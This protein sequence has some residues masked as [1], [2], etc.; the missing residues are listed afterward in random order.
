MRRAETCVVLCAGRGERM[1]PPLAKTVIDVGGKPIF[2]YVVEFWK[3]SVDRFV[4]VVGYKKRDVINEAREL[5]VAGRCT[6]VNQSDP[7]GIAH[8]VSLVRRYVGKDFIVA[9]GDCLQTGAFANWPGRMDCG[10]GVWRGGCD[11][12]IRQGYSV[13]TEDERV[14]RVVEKP[15]G[16]DI[17]GNCGMGTYYFNRKVFEHIARTPPS[18]LRNE[19]EITDVVQGMINNGYDVKPLWFNGGYI[20]VTYVSDLDRAARMV[21]A[22]AISA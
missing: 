1:L 2:S 15:R 14:V 5:G 20:N 12:D 21:S 19:V 11:A 4:F 6:F 9:L 13:E 3:E 22:E 17:V 18:S 10:V 8:A 7:K 16:L